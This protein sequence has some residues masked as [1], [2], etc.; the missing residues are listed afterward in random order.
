MPSRWSGRWNRG[1]FPH[2]R[3]AQWQRRLAWGGLVLTTSTVGCGRPATQAD[4]DFIVSRIAELELSVDKSTDRTTVEKQ[5][6]DTTQEFQA[7]ARKECVGKRVT[8][9]A[10]RCVKEAKTAEEIVSECLN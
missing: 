4:C 3:W 7:K 8:E 1:S 5:V 9:S 6:A 2:S 10:L